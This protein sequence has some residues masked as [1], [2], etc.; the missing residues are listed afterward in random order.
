MLLSLYQERINFSILKSTIIYWRDC[1]GCIFCASLHWISQFFTFFLFFFFWFDVVK[2]KT[3]FFFIQIDQF[4]FCLCHLKLHVFIRISYF[5]LFKMYV[6]M[7]LFILFLYLFPF[8]WVWERE[9][10]YLVESMHACM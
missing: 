6:S 1:S 3:T 2:K 8:L 4:L 9:R 10:I 7:L 5:G